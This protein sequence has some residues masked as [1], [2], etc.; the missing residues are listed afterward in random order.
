M[1]SLKGLPLLLI[2]KYQDSDL[3]LSFPLSNSV[4]PLFQLQTYLGLL[5]Y[6]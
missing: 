2:V 1:Y 3:D 4:L 5:K 6:I